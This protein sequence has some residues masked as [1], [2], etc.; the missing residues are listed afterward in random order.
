MTKQALI[1]V[2]CFLVLTLLTGFLYPAAVTLVAKAVFSEKANGSLVKN[3]SGVVVGSA[4]LAQEFK[5]E[6]YFWPRPSAVGY[7]PLPS[8]GSNLGLTSK[9][10]AGKQEERKKA[11]LSGE[12]LAASASGL[13]PHISPE[14]ALGQVARVAAARNAEEEGIRQFV[15]AATEARQ[16]G[17]LGKPRVNVLRLNLLLD[18]KLR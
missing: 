3:E 18:E 5:A 8:G 1:A 14:T 17:F 6:K 11:G 13:D 12:M 9:A 15:V 4:L 2:R 10:L 7:N 16:L